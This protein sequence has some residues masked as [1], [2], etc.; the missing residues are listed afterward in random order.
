MTDVAARENNGHTRVHAYFLPF[1]PLFFFFL[2]GVFLFGLVTELL[3][4][5]LTPSS[6]SSASS[7]SLSPPL[8]PVAVDIDDSV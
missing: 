8:D 1:L 4:P 7:A 3:V 2:L 5:D 6:S